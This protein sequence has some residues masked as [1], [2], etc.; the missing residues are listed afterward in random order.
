MKVSMFMRKEWSRFSTKPNYTAWISVLLLTLA[1][2]GGNTD[3][4]SVI[5][6]DQQA[7][8]ASQQSNAFT[9]IR[10]DYKLQKP[11]F[12]YSSDNPAY[13]SIQADIAENVHDEQ[14]KSVIRIDI[15]KINGILPDLN[16]TFSIGESAAYETFPGFFY[17]FNGQKSV[18]KKVE[19]GIISF[20]FNSSGTVS[21]EYDVIL[22]DYD[23]EIIPAPQYNIAGS[24]K[25]D[26]GTYGP[27]TPLPD[28]VVPTLGRNSYDDFCAAC[29]RLGEYDSVGSNV[30]DLSL[31]G[32]ELPMVFPGALSQ[33]SSFQLDD[34]TIHALR[35][36]LN[37]S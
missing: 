6:N 37:A 30:P 32:G 18:H 9:I 7:M 19:R 11:N 13:W 3:Q 36:F 20:A 17:V 27:A 5:S 26:V 34:E 23:S 29:H 25:F 21:G 31:R 10:D 16:K 14:F 12:Y 24:F 4:G 15:P 35:I 8:N 28:E 33:H 22:T 2:C 1:S